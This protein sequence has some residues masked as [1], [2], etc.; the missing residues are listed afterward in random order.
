MSWRTNSTAK[1]GKRAK[2]QGKMKNFVE[3]AHG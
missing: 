1:I 2:L 3:K